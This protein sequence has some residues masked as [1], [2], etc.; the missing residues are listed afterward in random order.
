MKLNIDQISLNPAELARVNSCQ[1]TLARYLELLQ[2]GVQLPP[3]TVF[4]NGHNYWLADGR[5]RVEARRQLGYADIETQVRPGSQRDAELYAFSANLAHGLA[6][7]P[8]DRKKAAMILLQDAEWKEFPN[9]KI[10]ELA[11]LSHTT[12]GKI[13]N[14]LETVSKPTQPTA[15]TNKIR[16][17]VTGQAAREA[18]PQH[19]EHSSEYDS[20][21]DQLKELSHLVVELTSEN[22]R[23]REK[24]A[25]GGMD[26]SDSEK[27]NI[28]DQL[29]ELHKKLSLAELE[30]QS[31]RASRDN[32][33]N[34]EAEL[35]LFVKKLQHVLKKKD[36]EI[37]DLQDSLK[38]MEQKVLKIQD[39]LEFELATRV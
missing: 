12:I 6:S 37:H 23:L 39:E 38:K 25:L 10:A 2:A 30:S 7:S 8:A 4:H 18:A 27:I 22:E 19:A 24:L 5:H 36:Q 26:L 17:R 32:Y 15:S 3:V 13:R 33:M 21:A 16:R 11:G 9:R 34:S 29:E 28:A 14:E 31:L 35:K 20:A 1:Q